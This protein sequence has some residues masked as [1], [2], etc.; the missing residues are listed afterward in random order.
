LKSSSHFLQ[1]L[2]IRC[3]EQFEDQCDQLTII[4]PNKRAGIYFAR[5]LSVLY[6]KPIWSPQ[7]YSLEEFIADQQDKQLADELQLNLLLYQC[8]QQLVPAAE[9]F[10]AFMPWGEMILKDFNDIDNY[11]VDADHIFRVIKSQKELDE[12]FYFLSDRDQKIIQEF[13]K[14]FLPKPSQKQDEFIKTWSVLSDLYKVFH[15]KLDEQNL[16]YKG[17]MF[18]EYAERESKKDMQVWFAGF[19]ALTRAEEKII[20]HY[21]D[22]DGGDIFWDVDDYYFGDE[23]QESGLFFREYSRDRYFQHSIK[24]D[25]KSLLN[26][27]SKNVEVLA[28]S[29]GMGQI[30]AATQKLNNDLL[31]GINPAETLM[32]LADEALLDP[33]VHHLPSGLDKVNVTMGWPLHSS[34]IYLLISRLVALKGKLHDDKFRSFQHGEVSGLMEFVHLLELDGS[35][36]EQFKQEA[37]ERNTLYYT[38]EELIRWIPTVEKLMDAQSTAEFMEELGA[39][40]RGMTQTELN[41]LDNAVLAKLYQNIKHLQWVFSQ[42]QTEL[43]FQSLTKVVQKLGQSAKVP[44]SGDPL[45][46]L[47]VMGILETRNLSYDNV[48]ILGMNEGAWPRDSSNSSFIP[49]NIRRAFDLPTLEHQDAMQSYLFY[50]LIHSAE[51]VWISY[52]NVTEYN[53]NGE[54]SRFVQQLKHESEISIVE[55]QVVS[56]IE[57]D[58]IK[59]I[60]IEKDTSVMAM[61]NAYLKN[62]EGSARQLSPSALNTYLD[63]R[64]RFYFQYVERLKEPAALVSDIDPSL[65]G[66]LLHGTMERLYLDGGV[67]NQ[68]KLSEL[69]DGIDEA[70]RETFRDEKLPIEESEVVV[71]RQII[72]YE[73]V[74]KY[75]E[76]ILKFDTHQTPFEIQNLEEE[77]SMDMTLPSGDVIAVKGIIDRVDKYAD[78]IR[79]MDYKSGRD[80]RVFTDV[81]SLFDRNQDKRSKA[82]FQLFY[83]GLLYLYN[84]P[85]DLPIRPGIFNSK[86]LFS[87]DFDALVYQKEGRSKKPVTVFSDYQREFQ[88]YLT[89]LVA[90]IFDPAVAFDQTEDE[91]KCQYCPY[92]NICMKG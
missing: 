13:W 75:I 25:L 55:K 17:R 18:R 8:Y 91:R 56:P 57:P 74:K 30:M 65:L 37:I 88:T 22:Q 82:V 11:L 41:S 72:A 59:S 6:D 24:R 92:I 33:L 39:L 58:Q 54:L 20:K 35:S 90:E 29:F 12:A 26:S 53:H 40:L 89:Q 45:D 63:C 71:G 2:A 73:V 34:S 10:D 23:N 61:L 68:E 62:A 31:E 16:S 87:K 48:M 76:Q 44:L 52:N 49:F 28:A 85:T 47:Q 19:N 15:K 46:G 70:L 5:H 42:S 14:G 36:Y 60:S 38:K 80:D 69:S 79:I 86:D 9:S 50:R 43:S 4:F 67:M 1:N 21:L 84:Y 51:H 78:V 77:L 32:V 3:Q 27:K 64:L 81:A 83:Y 66:N 7:I